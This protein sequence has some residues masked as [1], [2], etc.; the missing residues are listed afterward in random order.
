MNRFL[1]GDC[2]KAMERFESNRYDLIILDPPWFNDKDSKLSDLEK[3]GCMITKVIQQSKRLLNDTGNLMMIASIYNLSNYLYILNNVYDAINFKNII[4]VKKRNITNKRNNGYKDGYDCVIHYT[5]YGNSFF[6]NVPVFDSD[7]LNRYSDS[8]KTGKY[9]LNPAYIKRHNSMQFSFSWKGLTP[10]VGYGWRYSQDRM[11]EMYEKGKISIRNNKAFV[12]RYLNEYERNIE[13]IWDDI[14]LIDQ[15][16]SREWKRPVLSQELLEKLI[17]IGSPEFGEVLDPFG[18]LGSTYLAT[19]KLK[20]NITIIEKDEKTF[21]N[22]IDRIQ[23]HSKEVITYELVNSMK[24]QCFDSFRYEY[25]DLDY[26]VKNE[27]LFIKGSRSD[28]IEEDSQH[29][30]KDISRSEKPIKRILEEVGK[31][32]VAF[33]NNKGGSLFFGINDTGKIIGVKLSSKER[34]LTRREIEAKLKR[35]K[36]SLL[37]GEFDIEFHQIYDSERHE[38]NELFIVELIIYVSI[39]REA[40]YKSQNGSYYIKAPAALRKIKSEQICE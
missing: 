16:S 40:F 31:Y 2:V 37:P 26:T 20:R 33:K 3:Y 18:G 11:E 7:I 10:P 23:M 35:T 32:S 24:N 29:E 15:K 39:H 4:I 12:K 5:K 36:P 27:Y 19:H 25:I 17:K 22:M 9:L 8:D 21:Q 38:I 34:D 1:Y 30:F 28:F 6:G 14:T 13:N